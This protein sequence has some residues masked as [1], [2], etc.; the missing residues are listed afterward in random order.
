MSE[1]ALQTAKRRNRRKKKKNAA[2]KPEGPETGE[3]ASGGGEGNMPK[4]RRSETD[5]LSDVVCLCVCTN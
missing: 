1:P 3:T 4:V 5:G 2:G